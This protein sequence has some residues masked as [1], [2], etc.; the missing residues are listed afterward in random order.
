MSFFFAGVSVAR[1]SLVVRA[2]EGAAAAPAKKPDIGPKRGSRVRKRM[3]GYL[4]QFISIRLQYSEENAELQCQ[5]LLDSF[6]IRKLNPLNNHSDRFLKQPCVNIVFLEAP[7]LG[8]HFL[9]GTHFSCLITTLTNLRFPINSHRR[10]AFSALNLT[11]TAR[12]ARSSL[13]TKAGFVTLSSSDSK[14]LTTQE[15][16]LTTTA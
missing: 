12:L 6:T 13:S 8:S 3:L 11:G 7:P 9:S 14:R 10:S 16:A 2:E 1:P 4:I 15:S 5:H